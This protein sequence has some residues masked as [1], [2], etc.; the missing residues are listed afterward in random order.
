MKKLSIAMLV[1][2]LASIFIPT[3]MAFA[4]SPSV[5]DVKVFQG[6]RETGDW[7]ITAVYNISGINASTSACDFW[8]YPW[9]I[10]LL[11]GATVLYEGT[12]QQCGMRPA[13]IYLSE[14]ITSGLVWLKDYT[15]N[16]YGS[17][18]ASPNASRTINASDWVGTNLVYLDQWTI[19]KAKVIGLFDSAT[20]VETVAVYGDVLNVDG[21]YLF[22]TGIPYLSYYR[23]DIFLV[24]IE[25]VGI[26]YTH[27]ND[28]STYASDL[29][30][31]PLSD[32]LGVPV[33]NALD[34]AGFWF[35]M[36]GRLFGAV[37]TIMGFLVI[38]CIGSVSIGTMVVLGGVMIGVFPMAI[39]YVLVFILVVIFV[40]GFF[41]SST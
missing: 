4:D 16:I 19:S 40:R 3:G 26:V 39:I 2:I 8:S 31:T 24:T 17:W 18:G 7:L 22:D 11:D 37:I 21:G 29:Y 13:S 14:A 15:V 12:I 25:T 41:W 33:A 34:A 6:Y 27:V 30:T 20:Y 23:P 1:I 9:K 10:Q 38:A 28:S 36:D 5:D 32:V 35:G